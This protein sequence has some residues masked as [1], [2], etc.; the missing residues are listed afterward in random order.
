M[1]AKSSKS[2]AAALFAAAAS[3][4]FE[5]AHEYR[6]QGLEFK[7]GRIGQGKI[8]RKRKGS[9]RRADGRLILKSHRLTVYRT[10]PAAKGA[11]HE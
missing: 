9:H 7:R 5:S 11:S 3:G 1:S 6:G 10:A 2:I 4:G 8:G